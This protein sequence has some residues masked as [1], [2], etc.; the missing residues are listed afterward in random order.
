MKA[1]VLKMFRDKFTGAVYAPGEVLTLERTRFSE[2]QGTLGNSYIA[3][4]VDP[5]AVPEEPEN[6][7]AETDPESES[8]GPEEPESESPETDAPEGASESTAPKGRRRR[9]AEG[10]DGK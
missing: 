10:G 2:I 1:V 8:P 4:I 7:S 6:G 3:E 5:D 9:K